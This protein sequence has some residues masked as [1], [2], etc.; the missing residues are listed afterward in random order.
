[1]N[2][3]T[4]PK[5]RLLA[6]NLAL[7]LLCSLVLPSMAGA[8]S[9]S[10]NLGYGDRD[11]AGPGWTYTADGQGSLD[12]VLV[13]NG[14]QGG[15]I[16]VTGDLVIYSMGDVQVSSSGAADDA[17]SV[18]AGTSDNGSANPGTE[19]TILVMDGTMTVRSTGGD[20]ISARDG[21]YGAMVSI[22]LAD[23]S[24]NVTGG[25]E[26]VGIFASS[27]AGITS[28]SKTWTAADGTEH[29]DGREGAGTFTVT[30]GYNGLG[31]S[32]L[33]VVLDADGTVTGGG[34]EAAVAYGDLL[35]IGNQETGAAGSTVDV[36][37]RA[38]NS[39]YSALEAVRGYDNVLSIG[40]HIVPEYSY[41][42]PTRPVTA[43]SLHLYPKTYTTTINGDGGTYDGQG[44]AT[45]SQA[46][47]YHVKLSDYAFTRPDYVLSGYQIN[48]QTVGTDY[49][50]IP[51]ADTT[52]TAQWT[53]AGKNDV[54]D[55]I[56]FQSILDRTTYTGA[57]MPLNT[58]VDAATLPSIPGA[59]FTYMLSEN[60]GTPREVSLSDTVTHAGTYTV[61]ARYE[62]E[63]NWGEKTLTFIIDKATP[64]V[65]VPQ[66]V[67]TVYV[68]TT[69]TVEA[70]I[71]FGQEILP[72]TVTSSDS[73]VAS[74]AL[75][76]TAGTVDLTGVAPGT[77]TVTVSYAGTEDIQA[78]EGSFQV[79][80]SL[81]PV[82]EVTFGDGSDRTVH[83][84]DAGFTDA[85]QNLSVPGNLPTYT[86]S[87]PEVATVDQSGQVTITGVGQTTI[88]ATAAAVPDQF[89]PGSDSY[90]IT[91]EPKE[92]TATAETVAKVYDGTTAADVTVSFQGL[93]AGDTLALGTDYTVSA[94]FDDANVGTGKTVN[95]TVTLRNS[96][97]A[98]NYVL[99]G[100]SIVL[101]DG[102]ITKAPG[103]TFAAQDLYVRYD[104][105]TEKTRSVAGLMPAI[106]GVQGYALGDVQ[107]PQSVLGGEPTVDGTGLISFR[108]AEGL[109]EENVGDSASFPVIITSNNYEDSMVSMNVNLVYEFVPV[110][111][112]EDITLT[113]TGEPVSDTA[114][115]GTAMYDGVPVEGTWSFKAGEAPTNVADSG[116]KIVVFTPDDTATYSPAETVIEVTIEKANPTGT[117]SYDRID[118]SGMTLA[119][120]HLGVGTITPSGT[121]V[122]D[123]GDATVVTLNTDYGWT[124]TPDDTDNYNILTGTLRPYRRSGGGGGS[125]S[126]S[127]TYRITVESDRNGSVSVS[128]RNASRGDTVTI[129][130]R[131][132]SGYVLDELVVTDQDGDEIRVRDRG[133]GEYTFTMPASR[134][135]VEATFREEG[136]EDV[137]FSDVAEDAYYY[138]AVMWAVENGIT[139]GTTATT[140]A[141]NA[142]CTRG[143]VVTFLWRAA[144]EPE[145]ASTDCPFTDVSAD[146]YNYEAI[147][148]AYENGITGGT[149]ATTFAPNNVCTRAQIVTFLWR[150]ENSPEVTGGNAFSDVDASAYYADAVDWAVENGI[151]QGATATTFAP[152]NVC[153][154]AQIVTFLYRSM[155]A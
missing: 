98:S 136:D 126:G 48:G 9:N 75:G 103:K 71:R 8:A 70:A 81:L 13:L 129:T 40:E 37:L 3:R 23:G 27:L 140:F 56:Q 16:R 64:T 143:Q 63:D 46:Y 79:Q 15:P 133:D 146:A 134:V 109:T 4:R 55:A 121:I 116:A 31:I 139:N 135:T 34:Y 12:R 124:F 77:A 45:V 24:L 131:P 122:W 41:T 83:Y 67:E 35:L 32:A 38:S 138:D 72:V 14:Y 125:S 114:I 58:F 115:Q 18:T 111:D 155:E 113:Y 30:G 154:R 61:T 84:G 96:T 28:L 20:G 104:D 25:T 78:A 82:Q 87:D 36:T 73:S 7:V 127:G 101:Q 106:A 102:E 95:V 148:W 47:P 19:L 76:S 26:G 119:D 62:D 57:A 88:T 86:S 144:G 100:S 151:T 85:A 52:V 65:T 66:A 69:S 43:Y 132:D 59:Q 6:L 90:V 22:G 33:E 99:A 54:S 153:T 5:V 42:Y 142:G 74:A 93:V 10:I 49:E 11:M 108:L 152:N 145:P 89:A 117:P 29:Y 112:A 44:S 105:V 118:Q 130:V 50:F 97:V 128:P 92:I 1:M 150:S 137:W 51:T 2:R 94:N 147:L 17:I 60:G 80:V 53:Y 149:T 21:S 110:V 91:V 120:A 123:D 141:P 107:D 39:R 68:E